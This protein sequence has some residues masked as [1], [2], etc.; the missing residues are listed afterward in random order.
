M[1]K[2]ITS[3]LILL[4]I[5]NGCVS[6]RKYSELNKA[7][8]LSDKLADSLIVSNKYLNDKINEIDQ[9]RY[10]YTY[11]NLQK[12]SIIHILKI[13]LQ[14]KE[15]EKILLEEKTQEVSDDMKYKYE[16]NNETITK[17]NDDIIKIKNELNILTEQNKKNQ[18]EYKISDDK[19]NT[20]IKLLKNIIKSKELEIK[21]LNKEIKTQKGKASW[22]RKVNNKN[23]E[24]IEK[25][26][27]QVNV[28]KKAISK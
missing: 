19:K 4:I 6:S 25:L 26:T 23:K 1:K 18:T 17:L 7:K 14:G 21:N 16:R 22:L 10:D 24:E 9:I 13:E 5:F 20:E 8:T 3:M 28:L 12:D 2:T 15:S 11:S 27:N